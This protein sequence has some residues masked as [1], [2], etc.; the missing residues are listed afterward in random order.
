V[1]PHPD[2]IVP[3]WP[4]PD[5]V[6]A[7]ITTRHGGVS[8][9]PFTSLN[10]GLDTGDDLQAVAANRA[11]VRSV[12]P[13]EPRWLRQ[14][15][16]TRVVVADQVSAPPEADA[17][18]AWHAG[19]V[20]AVMIADCLPVLITDIMGSVVALAHAGW[21]GLAGGVVEATV[22][23]TGVAPAGLLAFLGPCIGPA[24]FEVGA[25]VHDAFVTADPAAESGF[26]RHRSGKWLASLGFLAR[27][28]LA[29]AG[30]SRV[31]GE[32]QCTYS[33]PERFFSYR[34]ERTTGRMVAL[35]WRT[36]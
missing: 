13:Q 10:L 6:R 4:A 7:L 3:D 11:R 2:W 16:G 1:T 15:H 20:C 24:A 27:Q 35:I 36:S 21:R 9:G 26:T 33:C 19:T 17:S 8:R 28:A 31:Y 14:V 34:R 5:C 25:D 23:E 12:L 22:R 18:V 29:R 32:P 30:V